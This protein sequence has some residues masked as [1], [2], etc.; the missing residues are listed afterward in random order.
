MTL[1][2]LQSAYQTT[3]AAEATAKTAHDQAV[4]AR[5]GI[6][7][8]LSREGGPADDKRVVAADAAIKTTGTAAEMAELARSDAE[9]A[10]HLAEIDWLSTEAAKLKAAH[11]IDRAAA[12]ESAEH[13]R[14]A[15]ADAQAALLEW[16]NTSAEA[17][18]AS[19]AGAMFDDSINS[20]YAVTNQVL[21][22][23]PS[24]ERPKTRLPFGGGINRNLQIVLQTMAGVR[25]RPD[26]II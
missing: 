25:Q 18:N 12:K 3:I 21:A 5:N 19:Q 24:S 26:V 7:L 9:H 14:Q 1:Q 11:T 6:L 20:A 17:Q 4:T 13:A 10:M 22:A 15:F 2:E 16:M 8:T 23:M